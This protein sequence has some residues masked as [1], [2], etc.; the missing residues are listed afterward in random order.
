MSRGPN[1]VSLME[2]TH[3]NM[4]TR[5]VLPLCTDDLTTGCF[6]L[7]AETAA[8]RTSSTGDADV[9]SLNSGRVIYW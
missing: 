4:D 3:C 9:G 7:E 6:D 8:E 5:E 1:F 2:G